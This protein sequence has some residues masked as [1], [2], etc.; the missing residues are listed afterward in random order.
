[1]TSE[2]PIVIGR[3]RSQIGPCTLIGGKAGAVTQWRDDRREH[4]GSDELTNSDE[5]VD[6]EGKSDDWYRE[7]AKELY[8]ADGEIEVDS[9][10]RIS[11]GEDRGAYV[12]AWV[13]VPDDEELTDK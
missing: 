5:M 4:M 10:A 11:R 1:M 9:N 2:T 3:G 7:R 6:G 8:C 12:E 13:W